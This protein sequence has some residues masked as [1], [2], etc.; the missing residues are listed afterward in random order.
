MENLP[1]VS[2]AK[3]TFY[4]LHTRPIN[5]IYRRVIEELLVE[6][7][8][9]SVNVSFRYDPFYALGVVTTFDRFMQGY[10]PETDKDPIFSALCKAAGGEPQTYRQDSEQL[11]TLAKNTPLT[12]LVDWLTRTQPLPNAGTLDPVVEAIATQKNP[13]KYSRLFAV[14]LFTTLETADP[15]LPTVEEPTQAIL[16]PI[17]EKF[18]LSAERITKD[19]ELYRSNLDKMAQAQALMKE[20]IETDRKKRE[21]AA[22]PSPETTETSPNSEDSQKSA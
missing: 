15:E 2:D 12:D 19:L 7:H 21:A 13:F 14:G 22:T 5:S 1:T 17:C 18:S 8:L 4:S 20:I 9:L 6:M 11:T 3:R 10:W 16:Q